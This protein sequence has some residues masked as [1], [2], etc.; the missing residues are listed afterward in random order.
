MPSYLH[1]FF[2]FLS[3]KIILIGNNV[4]IA[5]KKIISKLLLLYILLGTYK[6]Q[7]QSTH[8]I[9]YTIN[10]GLPTN[11]VYWILEASNGLI[12]IGCDKGMV[13]FDGVDFRLY[14]TP[15]SRN[16]SITGIHEDKNGV[17][18]GHN[19]AGQ[20]YFFKNEK[21]HLLKEWEAY[22]MK[23]KIRRMYLRDQTLVIKSD[24]YGQHTYDIDKNKIGTDNSGI[25]FLVDLGDTLL[26]TKRGVFRLRKHHKT[27]LECP[28]CFYSLGIEERHYDI[29]VFYKKEDLVFF[30]RNMPPNKNTQN[31]NGSIWNLDIDVPFIYQLKKD[32]LH[33]LKFPP[34]LAGYRNNFLL[35]SIKM[36]D[37]DSTIYLCSNRGLFIWNFCTNEVRHLLKGKAI[38]A[39]VFDQ[40]GNLWATS[41]NQGLFFIP[42]LL[43]KLCDVRPSGTSTISQI[44]K[45]I[46][47]NLLIGYNDGR[48]IYWDIVR[49]E[50]LFEKSFAFNKEVNNIYYKKEEDLFLI[51]CVPNTY[52]FSPCN[53]ELDEKNFVGGAVKKVDQDS[54]G[55]LLLALGHGAQIYQKGGGSGTVAIQLPTTWDSS[56]YWKSYMDIVRSYGTFPVYI[57]LDT[58]NTRSYSILFQQK[59]S[60]TIWVGFTNGLKYYTNGICTELKGNN[61]KPIIAMDL[62]EVNDTTL[63][64]GTLSDGIYCIENQKIIKHL[65]PKEGLP[66]NEIHQLKK[67]G[68]MF[69]IVTTKG[70][71]LYD[72]NQNSLKKWNKYNGLSLSNIL[73]IEF[74]GDNVFITNGETLISVP[75]NF[76]SLPTSPLIE[77]TKIVTSDSIYKWKEEI[78]LAHSQ[79][80]LQIH[81][82][83]I[84]YRSQGDFQ[85]KYKLHGVEDDWNYISSAN[86]WVNYPSLGFGTYEFEIMVQN[87]DGET[88][89]PALIKVIIEK[90]FYAEW[91]FVLCVLITGIGII[92]WFYQ[93]QIRKIEEQNEEKLQRSRLERDIRISELK[94]LK[95][96]LNPHFIFNALNSIQ[97]YII[98]NERELASDYLGTFADLMRLYLNHSQEGQISLKEE[99]DS[100][101]LYLE[102]EGVRLDQEF[103]YEIK[104]KGGIDVYHIEIPTMLVQ[105]YVENAIKHGLFQKKGK[106]RI[107]VSFEELDHELILAIIRDNGI[108]RSAAAKFQQRKPKQHKSFATSANNSRLE[109]LNYERTLPIKAEIID[110]VEDGIPKGTEVRVIIPIK[111]QKIT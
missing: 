100:L 1:E 63:L 9:N 3:K 32:S 13:S 16:K 49:G 38:S 48:I 22:S 26:L 110:L 11:E 84:S 91:W 70:V 10:E 58:F 2:I 67:R 50:K 47:N 104:A 62:A 54:Y 60:Y 33:G 57:S 5:M 21:M 39:V 71:V 28:E 31:E 44:E 45:D 27:R 29:G 96:Q 103:S 14:E 42:N 37:N 35:H 59:P 108:G 94:A 85:Y 19:F 78:S 17:L 86:K 20:I 72:L 73:D 8:T 4:I 79:N 76:S 80:S 93:R 95:A 24:E 90:P 18:W 83:G 53:L 81:F 56:C 97:D 77:I 61:G 101:N 105:P 68:N 107:E 43:V 30:V 52:K 6:G 40:E 82:L 7:G 87:P 46:H 15:N 69:W 111:E 34:L 55:N 25:K 102:L 75:L 88:S 89:K 41:L 106:K 74:I 65:T 12:W 64:V 92:G 98:Q 23:N 36:F 109:L 66:S 51:S 99:M